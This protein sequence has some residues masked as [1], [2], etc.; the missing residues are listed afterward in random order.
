K[1]ASAVAGRCG[2]STVA[3]AKSY[4]EGMSQGK[5]WL[6]EEKNAKTAC[7]YCDYRTLC[8]VGEALENGALR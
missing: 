4:V 8:R 2:E 6:V 5:F 7:T 1:L 3:Y